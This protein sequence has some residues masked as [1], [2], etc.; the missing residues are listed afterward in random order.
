MMCQQVW[1]LKS[2]ALAEVKIERLEAEMR[3]YLERMAPGDDPEAD[4]GVAR[5]DYTVEIDSPNSADEVWTVV[6]QG[7]HRCGAF[8]TLARGT[9]INIELV[10]NG[11]NLGQRSY[12]SGRG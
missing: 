3:G 7:A 12:G 6:D 1:T 4:R 10:H 8:V 11:T 9:R 5:V 2:A